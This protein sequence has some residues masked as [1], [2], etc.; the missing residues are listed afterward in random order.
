MHRRTVRLGARDHRALLALHC[1]G[2]RQLTREILRDLLERASPHLAAIF[3]QFRGVM[4]QQVD[5]DREADTDVA[6]AG[7]KIAVLMP[8]SSL[9]GLNNAP[10]QLHGLIEASLWW[11]AVKPIARADRNPVPSPCFDKAR[12]RAR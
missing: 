3:D 11:R 5:R 7:S 12:A 4:A 10:P 8:T 1:R 2:I 9:R 6:V